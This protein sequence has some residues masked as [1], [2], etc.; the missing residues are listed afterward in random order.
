MTN[1]PGLFACG[2]CDYQYHG[3]NRLGANSLVSAIYGGMVTGPNAVSYV[4]GLEKSCEDLPASLYEKEQKK[5]EEEIEKIYKMNGSENPYQLH[6]EMSDWMVDN[7]TVVRYNDRLQQTDEKLQELQER[8]KNIGIDDTSRWHNRT[9]P[10]VRQLKNML[11]LARVI[12]VGALNRNESR[13]AHY[14]PEFPV[15]DDENWLKTTIA[16]YTPFGPSL[17]YEPVDLKYIAPRPRRY[18]IVTSGKKEETSN[19]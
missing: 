8:F 19:A 7:V 2:E 6:V 18:D 1:I 14:K 15:R 10:F 9:V 12:T 11:E 5:Q 13:G 16:T 4:N 3:G 17:T